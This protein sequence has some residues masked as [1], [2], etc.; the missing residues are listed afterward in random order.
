[1]ARRAAS[2]RAEE[3]GQAQDVLRLGLQ[4]RHARL[5]KNLRLRDVAERSGYSESLISKIENDKATPSLNTLH[6]IAQALDTSVAALLSAAPRPND[7]VY[8]RGQRP[9]IPQV[10]VAGVETDGT[11]AELLIPP[12]A[13]ALMEAFVVRVMPGGGSDGE[14]RHEGEEVGFVRSG[15]ILLTV[16][17]IRYHLREGDSFFYPSHLPHSFSNPGAVPCEIIW[18]NTPPTL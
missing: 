10:A 4:L 8:R 12:G 2:R 15:E 14:R 3:A 16:S 17:G 11:E 18:V 9:L 7:V 13:S 6:R 5:V 1:M